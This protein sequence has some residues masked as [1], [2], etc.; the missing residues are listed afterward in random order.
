MSSFRGRGRGLTWAPCQTS[1]ITCS[2][3][4]A[5]WSTSFANSVTHLFALFLLPAQTH[6]FRIPEN[7][8]GP[9]GSPLPRLLSGQGVSSEGEA[10]WGQGWIR[11]GWVL[12]GKGASLEKKDLSQVSEEKMESGKM[13]RRTHQARQIR[14]K[15]L[16]P[17]RR[18]V[19][20]AGLVECRA[21]VSQVLPEVKTR[22]SMC[23]SQHWAVKMKT[24]EAG[25]MAGQ[26]PCI[27]RAGAWAPC[28]SI[29]LKKGSLSPGPR[30]GAALSKCGLGRPAWRV[31]CVCLENIPCN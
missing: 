23:W 9:P 26:G 1:T 3:S 8:W 2:F 10:H 5:A 14:G 15:G 28:A 24:L 21:V 17:G 7:S 27:W 6:S 30:K 19:C 16:P 13:K 20:I 22:T 25:W 12:S 29:G 31:T 4:P 18:P 11:R